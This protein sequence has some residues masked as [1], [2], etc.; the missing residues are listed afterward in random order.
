MATTITLTGTG[1]PIPTAGRAGASALVQAEGLALQ[2]DAGR[3]VALRWADAGL[4]CGALSA[5]FL[6]HHHSDHL[7]GLADLVFASWET[8]GPNP[9]PVVAPLGPAA[10]FARALLD[11]WRADI[12][13]RMQHVE[14]SRLERGPAV[15]VRAFGVR[16]E[17]TEVWRAGEV[18]VHAV[19]VHHEPVVPAVA[20]RVTTPGG[21]VAISGD[22]VVCEEMEELARGCDV[23]VHEV[24][25]GRLR[26]ESERTRLIAEYHADARELGAMAQRA[27]V[28]TLM[29]THMV[30][31]PATDEEE[32]VF[33]DEVR[34][35]GFTGELLVGRDLMAVT[36]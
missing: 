5:I 11:P 16:R 23:L 19:G 22:T 15:D 21:R 13:V 26:T 36:I 18:A 25:L 29:L 3:A 33:A 9:L 7:V 1:V 30:P 8:D 2:F 31:S 27:G 35:G 28:A 10:D 24:A 34:D 14:G 4:D 6:T 12:D 17:P 32:R 20:Y